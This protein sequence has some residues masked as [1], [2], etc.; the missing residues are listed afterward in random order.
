MS[1][2][3]EENLSGKVPALTFVWVNFGL[4]F[5]AV[6]YS[7]YQRLFGGFRTISF[8]R[9]YSDFI[10]R[11][12]ACIFLGAAGFAYLGYVGSKDPTKKSIIFAFIL[13]NLVVAISWLLLY[14]RAGVTFTDVAGN[15]LDT[16]RQL[17]W[18][19]DQNNLIYILCLLTNTDNL[20]ITKALGSSTLT[21]VFGALGG[22]CRPPFDELFVTLAWMAHLYLCKEVMGMFQRAIDADVP[23][24]VDLW[25]LRKARDVT[26]FSFTYIAVAWWLVKN[27]L[28]KFETG[29][30]H[31]A[32]GEF[33]AKIVLMLVIVNDSIEESQTEKVNQLK[34]LT[35]SLDEQVTA[36]N[37]LLTKLVPANILEQLKNGKTPGVEEFTSV[38]VFFSDVCDFKKLSKRISTKDMLTSLKNLWTEYDKIA[39][40]HGV[41]K[42]EIIGDAF[43]GIVG[44]PER[45]SDH[46]ERAC[47]F[48]LDIIRMV[49]DFRLV[50]GEAIEIRVGLSSGPV[51]AGILGEGSPHWCIIGDTV[52][53]AS[54]MEA[55]SKNMK[56]Q[57][58]E[59]TYNLVKNNKKFTLS[60]GEP[61]FVKD[62]VVDAYFLDGLA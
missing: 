55:S 40:K 39:K 12:Q 17:E 5:A 9:G 3:K 36:T 19:H 49:K 28:W 35:T 60:A 42:V 14:I 18:V 7:I 11:G 1:V 37:R 30:A 46:A 8:D 62:I 47:N 29:E 48:S 31:I 15:P 34:E 45:V 51:T 57:M 58:A 44:A 32:I 41:H 23:N 24:K 61:V 53:I 13:T 52:V 16:V 22:L 56:I 43:L 59:S 20:T 10:Y 25:T 27:N 2:G 21:F 6:S 33:I 38:T 4:W 50:S 54:K 26:I